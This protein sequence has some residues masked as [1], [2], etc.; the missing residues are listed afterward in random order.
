MFAVI[1]EGFHL[2]NAIFIALSGPAKKLKDLD[3]IERLVEKILC[4]FYNLQAHFLVVFLS[5][6]I[7]LSR[8]QVYAS[9]CSAKGGTS[10]L[11]LN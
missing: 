6:F 2:N 9:I 5:I 10:K 4:V 8:V 3:F 7:D 1:E 11:I